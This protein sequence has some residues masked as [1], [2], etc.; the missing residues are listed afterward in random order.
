M[1]EFLFT[2]GN[3]ANNISF[4]KFKKL[5]LPSYNSTSTS[6]QRKYWELHLVFNT[7]KLAEE[8][9][10]HNTQISTVLL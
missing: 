10:K 7:T 3:T 1:T 6:L 8:N 9:Y 5:F 2:G 4:S